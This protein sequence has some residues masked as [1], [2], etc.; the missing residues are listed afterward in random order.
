MKEKLEDE[1]AD[2]FFLAPK[3]VNDLRSPSRPLLHPRLPAGR[4][5]ETASPQRR[6]PALHLAEEIYAHA[7]LL[8][9]HCQLSDPV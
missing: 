8:C 7:E 6:L 9:R 1:S 3:E 4:H 2:I 5:W